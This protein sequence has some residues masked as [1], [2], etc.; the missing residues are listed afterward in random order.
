MPKITYWNGNG[1]VKT[2]ITACGVDETIPNNHPSHVIWDTGAQVCDTGAQVCDTGE[3]DIENSYWNNMKW[4]SPSSLV[5]VLLMVYSN[6]Q[7]S[8][9]HQLYI[10]FQTFRWNRH[11]DGAFWHMAKSYSRHLTMTGKWLMNQCNLWFSDVPLVDQFKIRVDNRTDEYMTWLESKIYVSFWN[12][13][14]LRV[15]DDHAPFKELPEGIK[16]EGLRD[17]SSMSAS[18][19]TRSIFLSDFYGRCIWKIQIPQYDVKRLPLK[20]Y[21]TK[22]SVTRDDELLVIMQIF[23]PTLYSMDIFRVADVSLVK[24]IPL[25]EDIVYVYCVAQSPNRDIVMNYTTDPYRAVF[26]ISILST[27]GEI[28]R[29]FDPSL[30]ETFPLFWCPVSF[31]ITNDGD[32]FV[33]EP[34]R[35]RISLL[36]S[37]LTDYQIVSNEDYENRFPMSIV[38]IKEKQQLLVKGSAINETCENSLER[39]EHIY[40]FHLSPCNL[41]T[42]N[43]WTIK[44]KNSIFREGEFSSNHL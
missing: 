39:V 19:S 44:K 38:Y 5:F 37:Q 40:V 1:A 29:T 15:F 42:K 27:D 17:L 14:L 24:S 21:P 20:N 25:P 4:K 7:T 12:L 23:V 9:S 36:N 8:S 2:H 41:E 3:V 16:I 18:L 30:F 10:S 33:V 34:A 32:I 13:K 43:W 11:P 35:G 22:L 6:R 26:L 31:A 28:I